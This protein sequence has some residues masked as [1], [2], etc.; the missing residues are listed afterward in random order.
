MLIKSKA[1]KGYSL[2]SRDGEIGKTKEFYFDDQYW[3]IRYLVA[4]TGNWLTGR[5]LLIS[6]HALGDVFKEQEHVSVDLTKKQIEDSPSI[7][8]D[9]PVSRQYET[10][11]YGYYGYPMYWEGLNRWGSYPYLERD[12][13]KWKRTN[14][15]E[16]TWDAHLRSTEEVSG[17]H[18]HAVDGMIGHVVDFVI[19]DE[20]WA[21]RYLIIKTHNWWPGKTLLISPLWFDRIS[22]SDR[23]VFTQFTREFIKQ[24]PE[25]SEEALLTRDL[26]IALHTHYKRQA[27]WFDEPLVK[28]HGN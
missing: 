9:K 2:N 25:Y 19:D 10:E 4:E 13:T 18:I 3:T 24:S 26:E 23:E 5:Q 22:W 15:V 6:P 12:S 16:K 28:V 21:I 27:Y 17:Y 20:S 11:Y 1:L 8:T 7:D 14:H